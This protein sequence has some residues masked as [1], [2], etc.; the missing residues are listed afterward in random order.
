MGEANCNL[1]PQWMG[2]RIAS[3]VKSLLMSASIGDEFAVHP[4][5]DL[6]YLLELFIPKLLS[7]RY[8]EWLTEGL[9]G[10]F[11]AYAKKSGRSAAVLIGTCILIRDQTVTPLAIDVVV[12]LS[13][14]VITY[15][16]VRL[17]EKG[18]GCLGISGPSCN[19][20]EARQLLGDVC[21]R[22][23]CIQWV[24]IASIGDL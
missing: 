24:Y 13:A 10:I 17:G 2:R 7:G 11:V 22:H 8:S 4:S 15:F 3:E 18:G 23:E 1:A 14:E 5:S 6:C 19:S 9:D 16:R 21:G 20:S 12:D